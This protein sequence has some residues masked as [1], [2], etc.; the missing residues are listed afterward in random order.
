MTSQFTAYIPD[1]ILQMFP[2]ETLPLQAPRKSKVSGSVANEVKK[3]VSKQ[4]LCLILRD[5]SQMKQ[6]NFYRPFRLSFNFFT[7]KK[8][9]VYRDGQFLSQDPIPSD[10]TH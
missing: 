4:G 10:K 9:E 3:S 7:Y 8:I 6:I 2:W 1:G 5:I